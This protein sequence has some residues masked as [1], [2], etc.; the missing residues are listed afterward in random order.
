VELLNVEYVIS[1]NQEVIMGQR[2]FT[3]EQFT[4]WLEEAR[5]KRKDPFYAVDLA[6]EL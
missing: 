6:L 1:L 4:I 2:I 5:T 3:D